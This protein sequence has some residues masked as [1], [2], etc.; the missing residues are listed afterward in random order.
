MRTTPDEVAELITHSFTDITAQLRTANDIV[1]NVLVGESL[2]TQTLTLI[3]TYLSAH[4]IK[5]RQQHA[6]ANRIKVGESETEMAANAIGPGIIGTVYGQTAI[7][8]DRSGKLGGISKGRATFT[9]FER[10]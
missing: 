8:L 10:T 5:V 6:S 1:E 3:E 9:T 7:M 4:F 2:G